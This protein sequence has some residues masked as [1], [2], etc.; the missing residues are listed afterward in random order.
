LIMNSA[1]E[2]KK[3]SLLIPYK[4]KRKHFLTPGEGKASILTGE[5]GGDE[6]PKV[7]SEEK[8]NVPPRGGGKG[9][10]WGTEPVNGGR[11]EKRGRGGGRA[12]IAEGKEGSKPQSLAV[13]R[14]G[15]LA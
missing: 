2:K 13:Q 15:G 4:K 6:R 11:G 9:K 10:K 3:K 5:K 7:C 14:E 8:K 1:G 12:T